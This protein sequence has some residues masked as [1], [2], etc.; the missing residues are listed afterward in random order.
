MSQPG[1]VQPSWKCSMA[2]FNSMIVNIQLID[3]LIS[4]VNGRNKPIT[5]EWTEAKKNVNPKWARVRGWEISRESGKNYHGSD[6]WATDHYQ[7]R[8]KWKQ[9]FSTAPV[10]AMPA[11]Y[12]SSYRMY[13][14]VYTHFV[15]VVVSMNRHIEATCATSPHYAHLFSSWKSE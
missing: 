5:T 12:Y 6:S 4:S 15:V 1:V 9:Q 14:M 10:S 7:Y 8:T 13:H 3:E 11:V 2:L